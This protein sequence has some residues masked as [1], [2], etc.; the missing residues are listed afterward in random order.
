VNGGVHG[1]GFGA[2]EVIAEIGG[3][4]FYS[5]TNSSGLATSIAIRPYICLLKYALMTGFIVKLE[6]VMQGALD[7]PHRVDL[8][9]TERRRITAIPPLEQPPVIGQ[10]VSISVRHQNRRQFRIDLGTGGKAL[11]QRPHEIAGISVWQAF[12]TLENQYFCPY[13]IGIDIAC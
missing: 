11:P 13:P 7:S 5:A 8:R 9:L 2:G 4:Q 12:Q 10:A 1:T 3:I 6:Y